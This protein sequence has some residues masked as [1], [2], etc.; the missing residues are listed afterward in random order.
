MEAVIFVITNTFTVNPTWA[1]IRKEITKKDFIKSVLDFSTDNL[2]PAIKNKLIT[3]YL[4]K[5]EWNVEK[6][7]HSSQ[8]AGPLALWVES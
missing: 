7:Y 4:K 3:N 6:I 5:D 8:A 2:Q 1:D